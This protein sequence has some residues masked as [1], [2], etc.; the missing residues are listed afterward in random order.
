MAA[1]L[2]LYHSQQYGNTARMAEAVA[3]GVE[4]A[5][6]DAALYNANDARFD[7]SRYRAFDAAA[8]GTPDYYSYIAGTMKVFLDDWYITKRDDPT[9]L[10]DKPIALFDSH[11]GGGAVRRPFEQLFARLGNQIGETVESNGA[12][13]D[14]VLAA[15]RDLGRRLVEAVAWCTARAYRRSRTQARTGPGVSDAGAGA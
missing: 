7:V 4:A 3:E 2:I 8:F 14:A 11:G 10:L 15:C 13:S 12:P 1:I 6:A 5:G 9:G